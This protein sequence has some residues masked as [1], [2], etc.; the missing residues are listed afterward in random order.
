MIFAIAKEE[1]L[2]I[3]NWTIVTTIIIIEMMIG[4]TFLKPITVVI[5]AEGDVVAIKVEEIMNLEQSLKENYYFMEKIY[6][7]IVLE[8]LEISTRS[9]DKKVMLKVFWIMIVESILVILLIIIQVITITA[10]NFV[11]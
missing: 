1:F 3:I 10:V 8:H 2:V 7:F 5:T 4:F 9:V 6:F 11:S